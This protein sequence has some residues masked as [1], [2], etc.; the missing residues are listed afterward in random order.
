MW[1]FCLDEQNFVMQ[2]WR[3]LIYLF[4][5]TMHLTVTLIVLMA[6]SPKPLIFLLFKTE[7]HVHKNLMNNFEDIV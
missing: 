5:I 4:F 6:Y 1:L 7:I 3:N 2:A